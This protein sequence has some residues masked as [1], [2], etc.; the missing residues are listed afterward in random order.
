[1]N[2]H[3]HIYA[4]KISSVNELYFTAEI[5]DN[6]F[7]SES[8]TIAQFNQFFSRNGHKTDGTAKTVKC[9]GFF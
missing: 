2:H 5:L 6:A 4:V 9:A 7:L 8:F 3:G 1:M